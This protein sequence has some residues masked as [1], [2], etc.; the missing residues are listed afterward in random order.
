MNEKEFLKEAAYRKNAIAAIAAIQSAVRAGAF[1]RDP[2]SVDALYM[3]VRVLSSAF[4]ELVIIDRD[5]FQQRELEAQCR[6]YL[7]D[8]AMSDTDELMETTWRLFTSAIRH[9]KKN[10]GDTLVAHM[11]GLP[12]DWSLEQYRREA[13]LQIKAEVMDKYA[14]DEDND[15]ENQ[16]D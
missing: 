14:C 5:L 1:L 7:T 8:L 12:N 11:S 13:T 6:Q 3:Q 2:A 16:N 15:D 10:I 4:P 9:I